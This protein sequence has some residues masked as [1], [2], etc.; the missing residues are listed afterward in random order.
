[1]VP[2]N[3]IIEN[4]HK[5]DANNK[6]NSKHTYYVVWILWWNLKNKDHPIT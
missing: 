1:M 4:I 5:V 2:N 3:V 6:Q